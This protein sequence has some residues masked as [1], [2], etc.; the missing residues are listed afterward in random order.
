MAAFRAA[1]QEVL[2]NHADRSTN[3]VPLP[4]EDPE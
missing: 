1:L 2:I 3:P 4:R